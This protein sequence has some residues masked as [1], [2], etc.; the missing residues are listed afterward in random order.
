MGNTI[1]RVVKNKENPYVMLNKEPLNNKKLSWKAKGLLAYLLSL[2]D[3]WKI[4]IVD[5]TN[6]SEDGEVS[7]RAGIKELIDHGYIF[8]QRGRVEHGRFA[9]SIYEVYENP[10]NKENKQ[11]NLDKKEHIDYTDKNAETKTEGDSS[12][13]AFDT[14]LLFEKKKEEVR[15][16]NELNG[17]SE[18]VSQYPEDVQSTLIKFLKL[19]KINC[20]EKP[21]NGKGK[22]ALWISDVRKVE[23]EAGKYLD[24]ALINTHDYW[25]TNMFTV[26]HPGAIINRMITEIGIIRQKESENSKPF[27]SQQTII[28]QDEFVQAPK[29]LRNED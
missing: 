18:N 23:K 5:L 20:P 27:V 12:M 1:F 24:I 8:Y 22:Y 25:K 15:K 11:N 16:K 14:M 4:N 29:S 10:I 6:R 7:T 13:D 26:S 2:P 19:W 21:K 17:I 3:N 9:Q 28:E